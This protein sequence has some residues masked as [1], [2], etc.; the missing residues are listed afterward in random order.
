MPERS[1]QV[2]GLGQCCLDY[3]GLVDAYPPPDTKY[4]VREMIVQG[5]GPVGTAL[6]ALA[7]WGVPCTVASVIADDRFGP[8]IKASLDDEGVDTSGLMVRKGSDSQF[9]YI[10]ADPQAGTRTI[11]WRRPTGPPPQPHE[12]D[13]GLVRNAKVL[14]TDGLFMDASLAAA[15]TIK[16]AGGKVVVDAGSL[17]S[18]MLDLARRSDYF[19]ASE[20]LARE[21][22]GDDRPLDACRKLAELGP[23]V[24]AITLGERG[25]VALIRDR[26]LERP[27]YKVDA[28]DTTG[29][30]D[31]FHA[32]FTYGVIEGWRVEKS[33]DFGAWAAAMTSL[34][35]GGRAG[36]PPKNEYPR[37]RL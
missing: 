20:K 34:K 23:G 33:L 11:F 12:L 14:H 21:L 6:V 7:R 16:E 2:Y 28:V 19:L 9:S 1:F 22:V 13:Y 3:V 8:V 10:V 4:E 30:G 24:V 32:G 27:A 15:Q 36:I 25:Y 17:R 29:C 18:G 35:L 31:V 26:I 5:G 37:S